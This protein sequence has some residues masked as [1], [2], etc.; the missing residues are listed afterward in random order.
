MKLIFLLL[1]SPLLIAKEPAGLD[2]FV[3]NYFLLSKSKMENSPIAW[4]DTREG[5]FRAYG[6]YKADQIIDSLDAKIL[7]YYEAG[8]RHFKVMEQIRT[9]VNS[10]K[11]YDHLS[12]Q[13]SKL[14]SNINYFSSSR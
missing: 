3:V 9:E 12:K 14:K 2:K 4:Q 10:G 13:S 8:I 6:V 1:V 5:Y 7:S 11:N